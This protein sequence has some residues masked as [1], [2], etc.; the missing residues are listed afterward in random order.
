M[1]VDR[2]KPKN[3]KQVIGQ[4][5]PKSNANKLLNWLKNWHRWQAEGRK[6]ACKFCPYFV[7]FFGRVPF[8]CCNGSP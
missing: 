1:W 7:S 6:P 5:G 3:L 8:S 2:Y 4:Q